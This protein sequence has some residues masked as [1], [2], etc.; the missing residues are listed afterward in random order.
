LRTLTQLYSEGDYDVVHTHSAKAGALGRMA[1]FRANV[2]RV[3][4]TL[5]GLPFHEFQPAWRRAAYVRIERQLGRRTDALL[6]VGNAVAAEAIRRRLA[7]PERVRTIAPA[8]DIAEAAHGRA[9]RVRLVGTVG[10][11]DYQKA[12]EV[13]VDALATITAD[14]VWGVWIGDGPMRKQL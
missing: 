9:A 14:D 7:V 1:A 5:H 6:A 10:R 13:W 2:G 8:V 12:P 11:I 4:H 3:V